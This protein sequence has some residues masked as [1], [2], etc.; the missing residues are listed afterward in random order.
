MSPGSGTWGLEL[1]YADSQGLSN[2]L[3]NTA[4]VL[5]SEMIEENLIRITFGPRLLLSSSKADKW[6]F[7]TLLPQ[8]E[9]IVQKL[10]TLGQL[11][12]LDIGTPYN[13]F[14]PTLL[15]YCEE[16]ILITESQPVAV[17]KTK[18][19]IDELEKMGYGKS[20]LL[21]VVILNRIRADVQFT[22]PQVQEK[23]GIMPLLVIPPAPEQSYQAANHFQPLIKIQSESLISQ[24]IHRLS[25]SF[26]NRIKK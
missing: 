21:N 11:T 18:L 23:L 2:L 5:S 12:L 7:N 22:Q 1:G 13:P 25:E 26:T 15:K 9:T 4:A 3:K 24:Q 19:L 10:S 14:A 20:K 16:V 17:Q 8:M 6:D